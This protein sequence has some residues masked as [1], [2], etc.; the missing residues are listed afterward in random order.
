MARFACRYSGF[1]NILPEIP[2]HRPEGIL[3]YPGPAAE[4]LDFLFDVSD[5]LETWKKM[6]HC[7]ASQLKTFDYVD[8]NLRRAAA[9]GVMIQVPYAQALVAGNPILVDDLLSIGKSAREL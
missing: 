1:K 2:L 5:Q 3:H 9:L 7:H 4:D 8:W 6:M